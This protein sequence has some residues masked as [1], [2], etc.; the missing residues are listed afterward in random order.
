MKN[1]RIQIISK[2]KKKNHTSARFHSIERVLLALSSRK[3]HIFAQIERK[4]SRV[5]FFWVLKALILIAGK[6]ATKKK[7]I[8]YKQLDD[9]NN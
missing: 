9:N 4:K 6:N 7:K 1:E 5:F 8:P 3:A 2:K